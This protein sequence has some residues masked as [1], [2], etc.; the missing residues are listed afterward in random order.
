MSANKSNPLDWMSED[1]FFKKKLNLKALEEQ[2]K[3]DPNQ[4]DGYVE[5]NI[6]E[7]TTSTSSPFTNDSSSLNFEHLDTH[8]YLITKIQIPKGIHPESIWAQINRTQIKITGLGKDHHQIITLPV[9]V[10]PDMSKGTYKQ[11]SLQFRMPKMSPGKYKD[12]DIRY[13]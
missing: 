6:K 12:I 7:A 2:W 11:G 13:L 5:K 1:P 3:L 4:I 9:P 8:N 10:N